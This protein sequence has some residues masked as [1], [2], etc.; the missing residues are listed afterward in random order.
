MSKLALKENVNGRKN[1]KNSKMPDAE[2]G[3][4]SGRRARAHTTIRLITT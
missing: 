2:K 3:G 4:G 1:V